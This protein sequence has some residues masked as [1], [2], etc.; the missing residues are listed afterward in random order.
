MNI[1]SKV[2]TTSTDLSALHSSLG[3]LLSYE[4]AIL[5]YISKEMQQSLV[6]LF[7]LFFT[8]CWG[9]TSKDQHKTSTQRIRKYAKP[10]NNYEKLEER[11]INN[12]TERLLSPMV[13]WS[14]KRIL[15]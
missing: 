7:L 2:A 1:S 10:K 6:L 5:S 4:R 8:S 3:A 12:L 9:A 11:T 13:E 14:M 15:D